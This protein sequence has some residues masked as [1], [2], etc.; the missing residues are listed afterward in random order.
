MAE[1]SYGQRCTVAHA[2]DLV[3]ERWALLIVRELLLGAKRFTDLRAGLPHASPN[4]LSQRLR[5]LQDAA[6]IRR[7][8]L[9]PPASSWVYELTGWGR[10]LEPVVTGLA[11]WGASSPCLPA[12]GALS[13]D[14][15]VLG[16][17]AFF[18]PGDDPSWQAAC[19]L[20]IGAD[21]FT[22]RVTNGQIQVEHGQTRHPDAIME[23]DPGTFAGFLGNPR[24]LTDAVRSGR[25]TVTGDADTAQRLIQAV[26]IPTPAASETPPVIPRS[27]SS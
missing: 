25:A 27:P 21:R 12:E 16:L 23:A 20:H 24:A 13:A 26:T 8:M 11:R 18:D 22:A 4:V 19:D 2:L 5:E 7:Y 10:E 9:P 3:G 14:S 6:V 1:R 15:A 17:R